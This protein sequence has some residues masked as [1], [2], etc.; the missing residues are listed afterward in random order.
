[1]GISADASIVVQSVNSYILEWREHI[2]Y[3][4]N[5]RIPFFVRNLKLDNQLLLWNFWFY[6]DTNLFVLTPKWK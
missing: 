2:I 1:M 6:S 5:L 3:L 4:Y